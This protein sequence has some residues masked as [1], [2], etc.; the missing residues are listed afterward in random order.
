MAK[1][2]N[3]L[4]LYDDSDYFYVVSLEDIAYKI[5][6]YYNERVEAWAIDLAYADGVPIITGES[7]VRAYPIFL[8]YKISGL[9]GYFYLEEI[10]KPINE[11]NAHPF[12]IWK[13]FTFYYIYDDGE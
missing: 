3:V 2:V 6:L 9:S 11:T 7:L 13:Y 10:G 1:V 4:P 5:R 8:D 12:E